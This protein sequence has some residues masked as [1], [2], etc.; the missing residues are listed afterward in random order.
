M[1][2]TDSTQNPPRNPGPAIVLVG[3]QLGENIGSVARAMM[4]C[5][6]NDLRLVDPRDGW[7]NPKAA[8]MA[9]GADSV[10]DAA[11]VFPRVKD[12]VG[13]LHYVLATSARRRDMAMIEVTPVEAAR[14]IRRREAAGERCGI[15]FGPERIGLVNDEV[16]VA[17]AVLRVP[18][19]P[20]FSSL[21][22]G[23]AVLLVAYQYFQEGDATPPRKLRNA[24]NRSATRAELLNFLAHL[25]EALAAV[26][27]FRSATLR[28]TQIRNLHNIF[29][30][31]ELT[32]QEV[33]ALHGVVN[34]LVGRRR[35]ELQ[36]SK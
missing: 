34:R 33:R 21:N 19:N 9:S 30:R 7:P 32:E 17:D 36:E 11:R 18:L 31:A 2:G 28:P 4:N 10:L 20:S 23:Q 15:L 16:V 14:E 8:P 13:D 27:F 35:D 6:L 3:P 24:G 5:A 25:E 29:H 1:A 12:A 26:G 22:L